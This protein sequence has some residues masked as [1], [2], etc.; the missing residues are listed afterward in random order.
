MVSRHELARPCVARLS[1]FEELPILDGSCP[2]IV[3]NPKAAWLEIEDVVFWCLWRSGIVVVVDV[4]FSSG[5]LVMKVL[6]LEIQQRVAYCEPP[7]DY[8]TS[9]TGVVAR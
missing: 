7:C 4:R 3:R 2:L 6:E 8:V 9:I 1:R 5:Y